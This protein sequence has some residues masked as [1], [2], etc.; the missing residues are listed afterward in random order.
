MN[1]FEQVHV[2]DGPHMV[3]GHVLGGGRGSKCPCDR[4]RGELKGFLVEV[5]FLVRTYRPHFIF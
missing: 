3:G 4:E 1:R 5:H 2:R